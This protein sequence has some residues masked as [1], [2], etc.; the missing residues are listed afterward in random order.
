MQK[1]MII[2]GALNSMAGPKAYKT[3]LSS[4]NDI[5]NQIQERV[6][7][8][9]TPIQLSEIINGLRLVKVQLQ[10]GQ[11]NVINHKLNRKL[12]GYFIVRKRAQSDVWDS[13]DSN[14]KP[15]KTLHLNCSAD[16]VVDLWVF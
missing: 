5:L 8:A 14:P 13:Q 15:T 2:L 10:T 9:L 7:E 4:D 12:L 3:V 16:V 6:S 11:V 1:M